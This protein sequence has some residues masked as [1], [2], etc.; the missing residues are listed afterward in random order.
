[1]NLNISIEMIIILLL[2][3]FIVGMM[4]GVSLARPS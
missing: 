1:M 2:A 3:G 4:M